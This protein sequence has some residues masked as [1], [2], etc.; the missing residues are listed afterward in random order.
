M[1]IGFHAPIGH[2]KTTAANYLVSHYGAYKFSFATPLKIMA[3]MIYGLSNQ[4]V[5]GSQEDKARVDP[6]HGQSPRWLLQFL[7]TDVCRT[8][9]GPD[10]WVN[11]ALRDKDP[12]QLY[13]CDDVRFANEA[14]AIRAHGGI[15]I[16]LRLDAPAPVSDHPSETDNVPCN[17]TIKWRLSE[18]AEEGR[19]KI[20]ILLR[21]IVADHYGWARQFHQDITHGDTALTPESLGVLRV[22]TQMAM[23][24]V[25]DPVPTPETP[26]TS[27]FRDDRGPILNGDT[28]NGILV[29]K[30]EVR[31]LDEIEAYSQ[32]TMPWAALRSKVPFSNPKVD[33]AL[34]SL[35]E[36]GLVEKTASGY[37]SKRVK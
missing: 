32:D 1:I 19:R 29:T 22:A 34:E 26:V 27:P 30:E 20:D 23:P 4:Q 17:A 11:A 14:A 13:V 21:G 16:G 7:G 10:V 25:P 3:Q 18:G 9:L 12:H 31:I 15:V 35:E 2:G 24:T 28:A 33:E 8:V 6:R 36:A 5:Y 37:R